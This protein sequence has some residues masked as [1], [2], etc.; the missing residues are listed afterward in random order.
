MKLYIP[1]IGDKLRLIKPWSFTLYNEHR[2][3][4]LMYFYDYWKID[5][6]G[7]HTQHFGYKAEVDLVKLDKNCILTIDRIYIRKGAKDFDSV[8]FYL[9]L[10]DG[11]T[12]TMPISIEQYSGSKPRRQRLRFW[13]KLHEVNKIEF[14]MVI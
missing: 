7:K 11:R 14:E 13:A 12:S 5:E 2:N 6:Y 1:T 3:Y 9:T 10:P 8:S 4:N